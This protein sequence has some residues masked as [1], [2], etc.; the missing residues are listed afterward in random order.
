MGIELWH[1]CVYST[2][3]MENHTRTIV[4]PFMTTMNDLEE[5]EELIL[6]I[7]PKATKPSGK[8]TWRDAALDEEKAEKQTKKDASK[9]SK[10]AGA[11]ACDVD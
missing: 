9:A 8:R 11:D 4:V 1:V 5:G 3:A 2:L 7:N 6:E 10:K